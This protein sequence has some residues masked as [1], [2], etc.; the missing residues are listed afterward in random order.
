ME[1][2]ENITLSEETAAPC[3]ADT[4]RSAGDIVKHYADRYFIKAL[5]AMAKGLLPLCSSAR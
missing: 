2:N 5:G 3:G 1:N 4:K